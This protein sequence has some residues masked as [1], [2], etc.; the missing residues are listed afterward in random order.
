MI[1][2]VKKTVAA[3]DKNALRKTLMIGGVAIVL[4]V[5]GVL[6]LMSGRYISTDNSYIKSAKIMITPE[7]SGVVKSVPI[8]DNQLVKAGDV[9]FVIDLAPY[10]IALAKAEADLGVAKSH[11]EELKANYRQKQQD[12]E[13]AQVMA[14]YNAKKY[15]R[16]ARLIKTGAVSQESFDMTLSSDAAA[17]KDIAMASEDLQAIVAELGGD[18]EIKTEDNP[19]YK[20]ALAA[21]NNAKLNLDRT[22]IRAAVDGRVGTAAREGD[23]A[24]AS[25]PMMSMVGSKDVWI[26][27]NYKETELTDVKPG[28]PVE[29]EV[30]TYPGHKWKGRVDSISPATGSEFSILPAQ[31]AT[32][33]W[34]KVVQRI[35][36]RVT[37]DHQANE[38]ELRAGMST[39]IVIDTGA[40]PH[41]P[42]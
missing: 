2:T 23:Y 30:D 7:V 16:T 21:Y 22:T 31:N 9:L 19:S 28:Q 24:R 12:I 17:Q 41:I 32:G 34:V 27:A 4:I 25:V 6:Y 15:Q 42:G 5:S 14:D 33:N 10:E 3:K 39:N 35:A 26:E 11:V 38:P 36:V 1:D 20:S 13:K 8:S 29:I 40:Y 37:I 18:P